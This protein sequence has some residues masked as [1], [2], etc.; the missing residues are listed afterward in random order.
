MGNI[1]L[2]AGSSGIGKTTLVRAL[3]KH[4]PFV[5]GLEDHIERPYQQIFNTD[6][7]YAFHNQMDYLLLRAKQELMLRNSKQTGLMDGGLEMDYF[8]FTRLFHAR[9]WLSDSELNIC[10][11]FYELVRAHQPSPDLVIHLTASTEVTKSR[12]A[13][14]KRINIVSDIDVPLLNSFI[15]EWLSTLDPTKV[16]RVDVSLDDPEY[17]H[18]MPSLL[19]T[20]KSFY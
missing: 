4:G 3:C 16:L 18:L 9:A 17:L 11:R 5:A 7:R 10:K 6:K 14:R 15:E 8:G 12:L 1:I 2:V 13:S 20:L 19:K